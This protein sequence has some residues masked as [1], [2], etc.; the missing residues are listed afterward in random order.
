MNKKKRKEMGGLTEK[1][2]KKRGWTDRKRTK[3]MEEKGQK[4]ENTFFFSFYV[5]FFSH[6]K[7]K[8]N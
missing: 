5:I 1:E 4:H 2:Q 8:I 3:T 6:G 7:E